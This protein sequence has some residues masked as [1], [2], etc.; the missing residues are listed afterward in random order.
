MLTVYESPI[1]EAFGYYDEPYSPP[2][3]LVRLVDTLREHPLQRGEQQ[4]CE[5]WARIYA[6]GVVTLQTFVADLLSVA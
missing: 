5:K 1:L 6:T 3:L 2:S 4:D